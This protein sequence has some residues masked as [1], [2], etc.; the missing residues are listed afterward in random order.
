MALRPYFSPIALVASLS[1]AACATSST[2][3]AA[4]AG[5]EGSAAAAA[6]VE[7]AKVLQ[8]TDV[9]LPR[10]A[11]VNGDASLVIGTNDR[12]LGR[13]VLKTG[14]TSVEAYNHF[15]LGMPRAGWTLLSAVQ[16]KVSIL[17]YTNGD[18]IA[19]VQVEGGAMGGGAATTIVVSPRQSESRLSESR[20]SR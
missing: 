17:T 15:F 12:W 18:R 6:A 9:P 2:P 14:M 4:D 16:G 8:I 1:L 20:P 11:K 3:K 10:D 13:V 5:P 19:T 7:Q